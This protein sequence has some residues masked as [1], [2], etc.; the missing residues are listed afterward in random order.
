M[1]YIIKKGLKIIDEGSVIIAGI[2]HYVISGFI[3]CDEALNHRA[4]NITKE[5]GICE[6]CKFPIIP[7]QLELF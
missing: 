6:K 4:W 5:I 1:K 3:S 2:K 7:I